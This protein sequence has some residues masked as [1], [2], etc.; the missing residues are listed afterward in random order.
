[1][2]LNIIHLFKYYWP[3]NGGGIAAGM[4]MAIHAFK[5]WSKIGKHREK[6][7][8]EIIVCWQHP[9]KKASK[10]KYNDV[11]VYRCKSLFEFAST[12]FSVQF[13]RTVNRKT[14]KS[15]VVFYHFPYPLVD[16]GILFG[17]IHGKLVVVW[18]CDFDTQKGKLITSLYTPLVKHTLKKADK[19]VVGAKGTIHGSGALQKFRK[20][21]VVIPYAVS[22]EIVQ[23][24]KEYFN[25]K[26]ENQQ[27]KIHILFLGRFVWYKGIDLLIKAFS[28]LDPD[29]YELTLVGSGSLLDDM[30]QLAGSLNL[31]NL[32][33]VGSVSEEEKRKWIKWSD[34][35]VLPSISKAES[36][37]IVQIEA[38]AF[39]KPVINTWIPS[40]VPDVSLD[41][42]TGITIEPGDVNALI[43]AMCKLGEDAEIR[44][45]YGKNAIKLVEE[46]YTMARLTERYVKLFDKLEEK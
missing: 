28:K 33:F 23:E 3:D 41:G 2:S 42:K 40:G 38:M 30:K 22:D 25:C 36:F 7:N 31:K 16:L 20:K 5:E 12:Q 9:G 18:H 8:Q 44:E 24:G 34:F 35:L 19:I 4:D 45:K 27:E 32:A 13:M 10:E 39:G 6:D 26:E 29:R 15:D 37:A 1:M 17:K 46:R 14:K 43:S 11:Q 21:C